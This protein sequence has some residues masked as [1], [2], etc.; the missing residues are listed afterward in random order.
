MVDQGLWG[1]VL[2]AAAFAAFYT[3]TGEQ[4]DELYA[5]LGSLSPESPPSLFELLS[6]DSLGALLRPAALYVLS[7]VA[8]TYPSRLLLRL[9]SAFDPTYSALHA[10]VELYYLRTWRECLSCRCPF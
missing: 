5:T 3:R 9:H 7:T 10:L 1:L 4:M 8:E 6:L 2:V